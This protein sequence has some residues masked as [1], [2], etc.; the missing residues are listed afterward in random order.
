MPFTNESYTENGLMSGIRDPCSTSGTVLK[1]QTENYRK[2]N[3]N[4]THL[5]ATLRIIIA[6]N[7]C[8]LVMNIASPV[9]D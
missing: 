3:T 8:Y 4:A 6:S 7:F 2:E 9:T 5:I 1:G